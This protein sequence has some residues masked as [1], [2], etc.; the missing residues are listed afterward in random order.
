[1]D[2]ET[3]LTEY[4]DAIKKELDIPQDLSYEKV[5]TLIEREV[6]YREELLSSVK[7]KLAELSVL[8]PCI[9]DEGYIDKATIMSIQDM[10]IDLLL[11]QEIDGI[12][13]KNICE[14]RLELLFDV[15]LY[16]QFGRLYL[17]LI[18]HK[19]KVDKIRGHRIGDTFGA[20]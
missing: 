17:S 12:M 10:Q 20:T 7:R 5:F 4:I 16:S 8:F 14:H 18:I 3:A 19:H 2:A 1:M 13:L 9:K 15:S 6:H 11:G